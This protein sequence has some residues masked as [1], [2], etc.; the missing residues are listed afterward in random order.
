[1]KDEIQT[2]IMRKVRIPSMLSDIVTSAIT[3]F[4]N[5]TFTEC[6]ACPF[7]GGEVKAHDMRRKK[8]ATVLED[9]KRRQIHV[10][11]KRFYCTDCGRLCYADSPFYPDTRIGIPV[12]DLCTTLIEKHPFHHAARILRSLNIVVD[13]GTLRNYARRN[14]FPHPEV[15]AM[16][17]VEI[18]LSIFELSVC[19]FRGSERTSVP[20][21]E[22]FG[23]DRLPPAQRA[24]L[25]AMGAG[26][27]RDQGYEQKEKKQRKTGYPE[28]DGRRH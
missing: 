20:G 8:F 16:Y 6:A 23:S 18:P 4:D 21:A 25:L 2:D 9:G 1:L 14:D 28:E 15:I 17:G 11:V 7:C 3:A 24:F 22:F 19:S 12:V 10:F 27:K 5:A 13:R 26:G